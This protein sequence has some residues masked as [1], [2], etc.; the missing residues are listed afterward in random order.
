MEYNWALGLLGFLFSA[1][2]LFAKNFLFLEFCW[3]TL[4]Q[5]VELTEAALSD[6]LSSSVRF[7]ELSEAALSALLSSSVR[8]VEPSEAALSALL[9]SSV[10]FVEPSEAALSALLSSSVRNAELSEVALLTTLL[11]SSIK[12]LHCL[13]YSQTTEIPEAGWM[14]KSSFSKYFS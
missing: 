13:Y 9:S 8:F 10:R 6:L 7:V 12:I 14:G 4:T 11:S 2:S 1:S 5:S 3:N